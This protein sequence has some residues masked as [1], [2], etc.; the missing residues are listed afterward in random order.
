MQRYRYIQNLQ[1][2]FPVTIYWYHQGNYLAP[3]LAD[4]RLETENARVISIIQESLPKYFTCQM[5]KNVLNKYSLIKK[6][7]PVMLQTLYY[8][9]T[10]DAS[11]TSNPICKEIEDRLRLMLM[12]EDL[13]IIID[14]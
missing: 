9:L 3:L 11:T 10:G 12:L 4:Q 5:R 13:S 7:T 2:D 14:L 1:L 6:V 8:D